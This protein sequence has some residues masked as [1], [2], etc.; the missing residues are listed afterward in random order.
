MINKLLFSVGLLSLL[1]LLW[2]IVNQAPPGRFL[3]PDK[4][5]MA[6][7]SH[8]APPIFYSDFASHGSTHEV[9]SA[10]A[11]ELDGNN[12]MAFWYGGTREGH[13]DV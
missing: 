13:K 8:S 6:K 5:K 10:T 7:A 1:V 11:I 12:I 4:E 9:H 3:M 2:Q